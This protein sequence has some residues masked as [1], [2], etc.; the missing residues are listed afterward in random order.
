[1]AMGQ[2]SAALSGRFISPP[3]RHCQ[4]LLSTNRRVTADNLALRRSL[5]I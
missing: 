5:D 4:R 2:D 3:N 1:L